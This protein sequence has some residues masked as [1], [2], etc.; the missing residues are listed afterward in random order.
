MSW[1]PFFFLE[2]KGPVFQ[3]QNGQLATATELIRTGP[4]QFGCLKKPVLT[5]LKPKNLLY[6]RG[7][8]KKTHIYIIKCINVYIKKRKHIYKKENMYI[9]KENVYL[10][11]K[12]PHQVVFVVRVG[13]VCWV[14]A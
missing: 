1:A 12:C 7:Y 3:P 5:G 14:I 2:L 11:R 10:K 13:P 9:K 6:I 8:T 4:N